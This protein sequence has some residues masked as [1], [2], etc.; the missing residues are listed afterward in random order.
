VWNSLPESI[1]KIL[2]EVGTDVEASTNDRCAALEKKVVTE[3]LPKLGITPIIMDEEQ[4]KLLLK[5]LASVWSPVIA[6]L[7]KPAEEIAGI[8]GIK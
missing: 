7:G 3:T 1:Q 5:K 2:F 6:K 4:N 8:L